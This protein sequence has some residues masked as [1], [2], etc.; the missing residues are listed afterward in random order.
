MNVLFLFSPGAGAKAW[1]YGKKNIN[2][3]IRNMVDS[4]PRNFI[5]KIC[6]KFKPKAVDM[7]ETKLMPIPNRVKKKKKKK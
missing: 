1:K 2:N 5:S 4:F 7:G 6:L 3:Y